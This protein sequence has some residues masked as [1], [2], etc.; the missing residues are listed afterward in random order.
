M[1]K[2]FV[3]DLM[4]FLYKGHF[5]FLRN[6]RMT[7][8]GINTSAL[9]GLA[10][11]LESIL[12]KER[13]THAV[14]AMDPEGPTFR[15]EA[16]PPYKAQRQKM[17]EDLAAS[18]P[19]A[20]ELAEALKIPVLRVKG[21][22]AD[23]VMGTLAAKGAEAG[24]EVYMATPDKD[25][26][27]L[28]R[29]GVKLYRPPHAGGPAEI[30]DEQKVCEHWHLS[31]PAQM[32]DYLALAG[33]AS[34]NIP[35]IRGVGEKTAAD[36]LSKYGSVEGILENQPKLKGKLA[37]KVFAGREDAK[38]SKFLTTI[39]TDVPLEP[40]W[41]AY[42]LDGIDAEKLAAV[43]A[44][45]ELNKLAKELLGADIRRETL[46]GAYSGL[47]SNVSGPR[48]A[49]LA[50]TPHD[51][52][53]ISTEAE[54]QELLKTL[55]AAPRIAFDTET[56]A[57]EPGMT[58]TDAKTCRLI[59]FSFATEKGKAWYVD[60]GLI[61]IFRPV[62]ADPT[63]TLVGLNVKFDRAVLHR[64]GVG[65]ASTPHDVMLAH[66]C[67][68]AAARHGMDLLAE[69]YLGYR[70]IRFGEVAG[71][72]ERGKSE[73]TLFGKDI[74]KV[75]DYAAEDADITLQL[76]DAIRPSALSLSSSVSGPSVLPD[77]EE[78]LV[79]VLLEMERAG[80]RVDVAALK[81][82]GQRLDREILGYTQEILRYAE[83]GF[84]PDSPKQ[85]GE[86]LFGKLGLPG[87]KKTAKGQWATDEKTLSKLVGEHPVIASVLE[88]RA[89][90]KLKSTYVDKLPTLIDGEGRVHTTY[91]QA[92]TETGR[93][94]SS[95]PNLQNIPI[96]TERGKFIRKAFVARD[97]DH[98]IISADYSQIE[99]R[100]M[101]AMSGDKA[102]LEAFRRGEDI[103]RDTASRVFDVMPAFVTPEQRSKCKM[104]NFGIIYGISAYGLS[105]RLKV[106]RKEAAE[107]IETYFRLYPTV[108][109]FMG[110]A[111]EKA[112]A[113][114]YAETVLGRRRTLRDINSRNA[115]A[116]QAAERDAINTPIQGSAADLIKIAMVKIDRAMKR[117]NLRA[118]MVLQIHDELV[119]DC[120][121]AE[122]ERLKEIVR[123]EMSAAYDFGVPLEVGIGEGANWL[124]AH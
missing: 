78:P 49:S 58:A 110:R 48:L 111:I 90:T 42:R 11:G 57:R 113:T 91:A 41:D 33:D 99:L 19:Y 17:P 71:E 79:K 65:I 37:E 87:G 119:F 112:R 124:D 47:P 18:I 120:P 109:E 103:H 38:I 55:M 43:C 104:V 105:Q 106:P 34:D 26:A 45:F 30:Y 107:L 117:E 28:V 64:Y 4:P 32:I 82:Y 6:P 23:D 36:L 29:P 35:G 1:K 101:A 114:G 77:V 75:T 74:A 94:S 95:D 59:G 50:D 31:S 8:S 85:L 68:D 115:T 52:R 46:D 118:K 81:E 63:K 100:L 93:L 24:F 84:N 20:F 10:N 121:K 44:K 12:K 98:V 72:Q 25:A 61:D 13:P 123:R 73:P 5:V 97:A 16:Y 54:A 53:Y 27:Q 116:R 7:A 9:L 67:L 56:T 80:V 15:H 70:T 92:F 3:I 108:K 102:M 39:R 21:F 40:D 51:Y 96:R 122:A 76:E 14:L 62:F 83:P 89:C 69:Q 22:E 88:Y 60:A 2:L 86:L 66:Y